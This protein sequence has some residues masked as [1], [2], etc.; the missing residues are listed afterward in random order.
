MFPVGQE[1]LFN[2]RK[3]QSHLLDMQATVVWPKFTE[4]PEY[5][6]KWKNL[7]DEI[8]A[9]RE[10]CKIEKLVPICINGLAPVGSLNVWSARIRQIVDRDW[11]LVEVKSVP[12]DGKLE[13][14][15]RYFCI[16]HKSDVWL[17]E[18]ICVGDHKYFNEKPLSYSSQLISWQEAS[19]G[20]KDRR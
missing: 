16:F 14:N 4:I 18:G 10:V 20:R 6:I 7:D 11:G 12:R 19:S 2:A 1:V 13:F 5:K 8:V 9:F 17:E 3:V 15:F